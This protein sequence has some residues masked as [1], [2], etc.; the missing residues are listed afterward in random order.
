MLKFEMVRLIAEKVPKAML[1][2]VGS[3]FLRRKRFSSSR[4]SSTTLPRSSVWE[5]PHDILR[6]LKSP[7]SMKGLGS[8]RI[9]SMRFCFVNNLLSGM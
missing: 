3:L 4:N 2:L 5:H 7:K 6:L 9:M 8:C 1:C